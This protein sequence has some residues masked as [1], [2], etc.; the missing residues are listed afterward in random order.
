MAKFLAT[1]IGGAKS[2]IV[3]F[4]ERVLADGSIAISEKITGG[5]SAHIVLNY[6]HGFK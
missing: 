6:P 3:T 5:A 1:G 4:V 2:R